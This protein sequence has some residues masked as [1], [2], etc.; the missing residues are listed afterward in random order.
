M[1][2]RARKAAFAGAVATLTATCLTGLYLIPAG[3]R[4]AGYFSVVRVHGA[5]AHA[6]IAAGV[7][8]GALW[9]TSRPHHP[10]RLLLVLLGQLALAAVAVGLFFVAAAS[11]YFE[12]LRSLS[13]LLGSSESHAEAIVLSALCAGLVVAGIPGLAL[14]PQQRR[15]RWLATSALLLLAAA[16]LS[17][18]PLLHTLPRQPGFDATH[19]L[20][21]VLASVGLLLLIMARR[22]PPRGRRARALALAAG[23][24]ATTLT[25]A[26]W[27]GWYRAEFG[28]DHSPRPDD[29]HVIIASTPASRAEMLDPTRARI[30]ARLLGGS[31]R[32]GQ[33]RCHPLEGAQWGGSNHRF[34]LDNAVFR[35]VVADMVSE[36]GPQSSN[37]CMNCHDP[38]GVLAGSVTRAWTGGQP[39]HTG[40]GVSCALCHAIT[41]TPSQPKN[42]LMTVAAPLPY[43]GDTVEEQER[44]ILLDPR[45]HIKSFFRGKVLTRDEV[46]GICHS[47]EMTPDTWAATNLRLSIPFNPHISY[48]KQNP[49]HG[50]SCTDC[51]MLIT[52]TRDGTL[53]SPVHYD[54]QMAALN[55]D[56]HLYATGPARKDPSLKE[57]SG[58]TSAYMAG[59]LAMSP[60][61]ARFTRNIQGDG[62]TPFPWMEQLELARKGTILG[63]EAAGRLRG[64]R[65]ELSLVTRNHRSAHVYPT[66]SRDFRQV[67]QEVKV[68]DARGVVVAHRGGL[69]K[70]GRLDPG[71][72]R[73]GATVLDRE[74]QPLR[75]HRVWEAFGVRDVRTIPPGGEHK[76]S[77]TLELPDTSHAPLTVVV[78]WNLRHANLSFTRSIFGDKGEVKF[79]VHLLGQ[80]RITVEGGEGG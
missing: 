51:H 38:I 62:P 3:F 37:A 12:Q 49:G 5:C 55:P 65:L 34:A 41:A 18:L 24:A 30:P 20:C 76:N 44:N 66:G 21:G 1:I 42:G 15:L 68:T 35:A 9:F 47:L 48:T 67:W 69:D 75:D 78:R 31:E 22:L 45:D 80:A 58:Y 74:G 79:P 4:S 8:A 53:G 23:L 11:G 70:Q 63:L 25:V 59:A 17:G 72:Y 60:A 33:P 29:P 10:W 16:T 28:R 50:S 36:L 64:S 6:L 7:L 27:A 26:G 61:L 19:S 52:R 73:L 40:E 56:L 54:H 77:L 71:A 46:C 32:C 39:A 57:V 43:P 2:P 13:E 14:Q